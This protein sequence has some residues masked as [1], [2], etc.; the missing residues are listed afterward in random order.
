MR[1]SHPFSSPRPA[2]KYPFV[3]VG[4]FGGGMVMADRRR[5]ILVTLAITGVVAAG[6]YLATLLR[7]GQMI[8]G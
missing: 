2:P 4:I 1:P 3:L 5:R 8:G 7:F 6:L